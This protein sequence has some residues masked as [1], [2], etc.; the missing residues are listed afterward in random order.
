MTIHTTLRLQLRSSGYAP[1]PVEGKRPSLKE[2]QKKADA[3]ADE[4][5]LWE[6]LYP[7]ARNT[8]L[9]TATTPALDIDITNPEAAEAI[10]ALVRQ[11]FEGRGHVLVR[12]G[13]FPKRA[14]PFRTDAPFKKITVNVIAPNGNTEQKM[15]MLGLGQQIVVDG[16]H[17]DT[18]KPYSWHGGSPCS[19]KHEDLPYISEAE[20]K[21]LV[22]D[23]VAMLIKD[24]GYS[25]PKAR[26]GKDATKGNG[27]HGAEHWG[28]LIENI[29][30]GRELHESLRDLAGKAIASGMSEGATV[31]FLRAEMERSDVPRDDRWQARY[32]DIPRL[33]AGATK[34]VASTTPRRS[35]G[36]PDLAA[37]VAAAKTISAADLQTMTLAADRFTLGDLKPAPGDVLYLALEDGKRRLQRRITKLLPTFSGSWPEGFEIATEWPRAD[38]GGLDEIEKWLIKAKSPRLVVIDTLAQFRKL[39]KGRTQVYAD[40]YAAISGL[41]KLA[42]KYNVG[43]IIVHHDRKAEADD[44]FDT[45]SG[46]LGLTGAADT[47][48][49]MKRQAG[50]VTL[51]VRSRDVEERGLALQ[52]SKES[53]RWTILGIAA[54][55]HR[56]AERQRVIDALKKNGQLQAKNIQL[57][58]ELRNRNATDMLLGK[59]LRDGEIVRL[60]KGKYGLP[61]TDAGQIRRGDSFEGRTDRTDGQTGT[62]ASDLQNETETTVLSD[63]LSES[64]SDPPR[65]EH[66]SDLSDLSAH[67]KLEP[68]RDRYADMD[69][70]EFLKRP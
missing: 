4:I 28:Y 10:E 35:T 29:R 2:W 32:D 64:L 58:A 11:R 30:H 45:V 1:V 17:P 55:I 52:F 26:V 50:A 14:V 51:H 13:K 41:Q 59:M 9:L 70:P 12:I 60:D 34:W 31:N 23:A 69:I 33:V 5:Q 66:P 3:N 63:G 6:K 21:Q 48:L 43:I 39:S 44:V 27:G 24:F 22:D 20:A 19:I 18:G 53:C 15:E 40:D 7:H 57:M 46:S 47:I 8:G 61:E 68:G 56:S 54:D 37:A 36:D 38:H 67:F 49:I 16:I 42:S 25:V 65:Q 62:Q